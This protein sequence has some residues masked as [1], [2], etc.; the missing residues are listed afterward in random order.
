MHVLMSGA[1]GLIGRSLR[2]ALEARGDTVTVL[3]RR[4]E[5]IEGSA[6]GW[7]PYAGKLPGSA[8][9]KADAVVHLAGEPI[10]SGRWTAEHK[11]RVRDSRVLSTQLLAEAVVSAKKKPAVFVSA[12]A[13]GFYGDRGS[14]AVDENAEP[15]KNFLAKVCIAWEAESERVRQANIRVVNPRIGIVLSKHGGAL[16]KM[17]TPFR[18]GI[19]GPLGSGNQYMSWIG[20]EDTVGLLLHALDTPTIDGPMNVVA[21]CP[22]TNVAF[23][24]ALGQALKRPTFM[25][26]PR[27][28]LR[29][30]MGEMADE[31]LLTSIHVLPKV[32]EDTGYTFRHRELGVCLEELLTK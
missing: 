23:T 13:I 7:D 28:A 21:P 19:G 32:A 11:R 16:A 26:V 18:L 8:M 17:M 27:F 31:L 2:S 22:V 15:G 5:A 25:A 4:P 10:V 12:S 30:A 9:E 24:S 3:S 29:A 14:L 1:T 6:L 20:L